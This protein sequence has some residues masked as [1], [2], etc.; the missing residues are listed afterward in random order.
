MEKQLISKMQINWCLFNK[1]PNTTAINIEKKAEEKYKN[2]SD[3]V[4][5][6]ETPILI[7][8]SIDTTQNPKIKRVKFAIPG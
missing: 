6:I 5:S 3:C 4:S 7:K 1:V 2:R 8:G